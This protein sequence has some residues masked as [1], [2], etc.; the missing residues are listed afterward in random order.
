MPH[1]VVTTT[2]ERVKCLLTSS[3]IRTNRSNEVKSGNSHNIFIRNL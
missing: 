2:L 3:A 1:P